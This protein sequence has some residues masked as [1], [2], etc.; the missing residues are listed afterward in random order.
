MANATDHGLEDSIGQ[1]YGH[2]RHGIH[3]DHGSPAETAS[4]RV[5]NHR[6]DVARPGNR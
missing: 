2:G 4:D 3:R 5:D 1:D 6:G